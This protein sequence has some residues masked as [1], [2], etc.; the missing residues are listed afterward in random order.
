[1]ALVRFENKI[2][3]IG[4]RLQRISASEATEIL[5]SETG[6]C[7]CRQLFGVISP[8]AISGS[9]AIDAESVA[10]RVPLRLSAVL[11][12]V[13]VAGVAA[14]RSRVLQCSDEPTRDRGCS[15]GRRQRG[16]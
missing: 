11:H 1:M 12:K 6:L 10:R 2:E 15:W 3:N 13:P 9:E 7:G 5:R 16:C 4:V 8:W 14:G